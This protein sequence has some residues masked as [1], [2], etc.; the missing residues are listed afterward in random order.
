[1]KSTYIFSPLFIG[2]GGLLWISASGGVAN[3]QNT[4]R[5]G[6]PV[7]NVVCTQ[8]H[9]AGANFS[10][11]PVIEITTLTGDAVTEY[12]P[13]QDYI[14]SVN[15]QST[16]SNSHG[17]Q[18][19]GMLADNSGAGTGSAQTS[20]TQI[21]PLN[22]RWYFENSGIANGGSY[23]MSWTAPA[24]GSGPVSFYG[25]ALSVNGN[26]STSGDEFA[27]IPNLTLNEA[28]PN[29][30]NELKAIVELSAFPNPV[31]SVLNIT[32]QVEMNRVEVID[33]SGRSVLSQV[34]SSTSETLD[35]SS[36]SAGNY[37]LRIT[38]GLGVINSM[39][40]KN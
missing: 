12:T 16:G 10:T 14:L 1:M 20:N 7:S 18:V 31:S 32:T 23:L 4:D 34:V 3:V 6:S 17:F 29:G 37:V 19:T 35:V 8:C 11:T 2:I 13:G 21:T 24:V 9:A 39:V 28:T 5:T 30:V 22:G 25:S 15:I 36:L 33:L 40:Q 26:G 27:N 38:T